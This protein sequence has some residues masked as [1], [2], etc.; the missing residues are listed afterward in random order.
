MARILAID[1]DGVEVRF[2]LGTAQKDRLIVQSV[3]AASISDAA[4]AVADAAVDEETE[5]VV[6]EIDAAGFVEEFESDDEY[7][8]TE[9]VETVEKTV[10]PKIPVVYEDEEEDESSD[11]SV[12]VSTVKK[13]KR[14]SFKSSPLAVTLKKLLR[15]NKVGSAVVCYS[16]ERSDVDVMYMTIPQSTESETPEIVFNQALRDSLTF[17][18]TQPLDYMPLGISGSKKSGV[19]RVAAVSIARDK[20]RRIRETLSGAGRSPSK[21][22]LREPSLAE[23]LRADF[24]GLKYDEPVLLIQELCDEV[25]LTLCAGK[26]V[27]YFRSFKLQADADPAYRAERIKEEVIRTLVVG[28]DDL[29]ENTEVNQA[30]FFTGESKPR[31]VGVYSDDEDVDDEAGSISHISDDSEYSTTAAL[32]AK[33]LVEA[34]VNIDFINPFRLPGIKLKKD[35]PENPGRYAS[36]LGMILAERPQNRPAIDLLH[37]REKPKPPNYG[38]VFLLYFILIGIGAYVAWEWNKRDLK[39]LE[40]E[41][42]ELEKTRDEVQ[43]ELNSKRPLFMTLSSA[44]SWQNL[45]GVNVL[46]E[47]RDILI[48][49]PESPDFIV[50][51][52]AYTG[53]L[54]G[55]PTFVIRAKITRV[56]L[57]NQ[58]RLR[59]ARDGSHV[60]QSQ[61]GATPNVGDPG[62]R[63]KFDA[64]I[65]C[66]RRPH[67]TFL[68]M[69]PRE[70]QQI[71]NDRPE[72]FVQQEEERAQKLKEEQEKFLSELRVTLNKTDEILTRSVA[73]AA[74]VEDADVPSDTDAETTETV[75][76]AEPTLE[77]DQA[78][79]ARLQQFKA[80][81]DDVA[82]N[83]NLAFRQGRITQAQYNEFAKAWQEKSG[84]VIQAYN[85]VL[86]SVN[87][88]RAEAVAKAEEAA[89]AQEASKA[90]AAKAE[91]TANASQATE[92]PGGQQNAESVSPDSSSEQGS[93]AD[94]AQSGDSQKTFAEQRYEFW[95]E[96][97]AQRTEDEDKTL[98]QELLQY[99]AR[100][101]A[102]M[103]Q[104]QVRLQQNAITQQQFAQI[105]QQYMIEVVNVET[106]WKVLQEREQIRSNGGAP[107]PAEPA[108]APAEPA[109]AEP[110]P[111]PAEPAP[112]PAEPAP[113]EPAP[114]PAP[115]EPA[116]A[117]VEPAPAPVEPAPAPAEPAPAPAAPAPAPAP[118]ESAPAEPAPAPAA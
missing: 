13:S 46:D 118:A 54:N 64:S 69:L 87:A 90:E 113:A 116:P 35:E 19:R 97:D 65:I 114:A 33:A 12:V 24:C 41:V 102:N 5:E 98:R 59:M 104:A 99:R 72:Y 26:D 50:E 82:K 32:L 6:D 42:V 77:E 103:Q 86:Q 108:S 94:G 85:T 62:Y 23:F 58:F 40:A 48:R 79:L 29:P 34:G 84:A 3:G 71:S 80:E 8:E 45:Q 92:P 109:P 96:T 43:M 52:L 56:E 89:K 95:K 30:I 15:E 111:A 28:I 2:A 44:N 18:E 70:L 49:L 66:S 110:A 17:N 78:Y 9:V 76:P 51:R 88:R 57:F 93:P 67:A 37:P 105:R 21:I 60:V 106:R 16:V 39:K 47:M 20:L 1:W 11:G 74:P 14:E 112:A 117:P 7:D 22:E 68:A 10:I 83:A 36:A 31:P 115:A 63:Y 53:N 38:L 25:N 55:R 101:D 27:L 73:G 75:Q 61:A 81:L 100:L 107:A 4:E 91:E